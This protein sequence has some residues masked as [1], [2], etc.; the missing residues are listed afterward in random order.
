MISE[1]LKAKTLKKNTY[2]VNKSYFLLKTHY[3]Y[4][5]LGLSLKEKPFNK[6]LTFILFLL[7]N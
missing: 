4:S 7:G 5:N 1:K 2:F 6:S 3:I